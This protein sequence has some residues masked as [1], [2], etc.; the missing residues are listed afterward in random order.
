MWTFQVF[1]ST[2]EHWLFLY[3]EKYL[4][5]GKHIVS[6]LRSFLESEENSFSLVGGTKPPDGCDPAGNFH[7]LSWTSWCVCHILPFLPNYTSVLKNKSTDKIAFG[8]GGQGRWPLSWVPDMIFFTYQNFW[9][10]LKNCVFSYFEAFYFLSVT[11]CVRIK[12]SKV[13]INASGYMSS[14]LLRNRLFSE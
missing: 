8:K 3:F 1:T 7:S 14:L 2:F 11:Y 6:I 12:C 10:H 5:Y 9:R 4:L 13:C